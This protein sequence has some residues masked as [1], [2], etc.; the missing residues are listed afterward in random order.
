MAIDDF[1][2]GYFSLAYLRHFDVDTLKIDRSFLVD[3]ATNEADQAIAR[4]PK[5]KRRCRRCGDQGAAG[6]DL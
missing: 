2:T 4:K 1:G 6:A 3:I 5:V